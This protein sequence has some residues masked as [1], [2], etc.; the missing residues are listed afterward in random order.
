MQISWLLI[1]QL[2][3]SNDY[4]KWY[5]DYE[6][7]SIMPVTSYNVSSLYKM[8][9]VINNMNGMFINLVKYF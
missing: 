6:N 2:K 5:L 1:F 9:H 3:I 7:V 4:F 8:Y